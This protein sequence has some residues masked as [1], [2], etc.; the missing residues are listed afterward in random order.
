MQVLTYNRNWLNR[1]FLFIVY[2]LVWGVISIMPGGKVSPPL[3]VAIVQFLLMSTSI[4]AV[5]A[6]KGRRISDIVLVVFVLHFLASVG[7]RLFYIS[8]FN[9][10]LGSVS[11]DSAEYN[12]LASSTCKKSFV[13]HI[14][15][16][17]REGDLDDLGI[18]TIL[19]W[20]YRLFGPSFGIH[21]MLLVNS[22]FIA[23][24]CGFLFKL[25]SFYLPRDISVTITALWGLMPFSITTAADGLKENFFAFFLI[26]G[27]YYACAY[28]NQKKPLYLILSLLFGICTVF[29]RIAA[30]P[31][32]LFFIFV[33]YINERIRSTKRLML[34]V[35][36]TSASVFYLMPLLFQY[37]LGLRGLSLDIVS[38]MA[39]LQ[40]GSEEASH[41]GLLNWVFGLLGSLPSFKSTP[42]KITYITVN[43]F[44]PFLV[45]IMG[46]FY[47]QGIVCAIRSRARLFPMTVIPLLNSLM[48]I[49]MSYSFDFRY[50]FIHIPFAL[51][52]AGYGFYCSQK[53]W[54]LV[55]LSYQALVLLFIIYYNIQ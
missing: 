55:H 9:N 54:R 8:E 48:I 16:L 19:Y 41:T 25:S 39:E 21:V 23:S 5:I 51:I 31:I 26:V 37:L 52:L 18:P 7:L 14:E 33:L 4:V 47:I 29:F 43:N 50:R 24:S 46:S 32:F 22:I 13:E 45:L 17:L 40:Y 15:Y 34:V 30:L 6:C 53:K 27:V 38:D 49:L 36:L 3:N 42:E 35:L 1:K 12:Y 10:P 28:F 2:V 44:S 20:V 11:I